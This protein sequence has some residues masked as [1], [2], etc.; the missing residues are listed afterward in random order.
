MPL[1]KKKVS[2]PSSNPPTLITVGSYLLMNFFGLLQAKTDGL[3]LNLVYRLKVIKLLQ[4]KLCKTVSLVNEAY[5]SQFIIL[6]VLYLIYVCLHISIIYVEGDINA[7]TVDVVLSVSWGTLD[8]IKLVY[9]IHLYR[10]LMI[11]V[12]F[13]IQFYTLLY[14]FTIIFYF[15]VCLNI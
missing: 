6:S 12:I 1:R 5:A 3:K 4:M 7:Y 8:I 15:A 9:I 11:Q 14:N 10:I 13:Q 2:F